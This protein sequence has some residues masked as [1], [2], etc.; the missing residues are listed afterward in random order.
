MSRKYTFETS[1]GFPGEGSKKEKKVEEKKK[2]CRKEKK[3]ACARRLVEIEDYPDHGAVVL[4]RAF[5]KRAGAV[6]KRK[7]K[8]KEL[9]PQDA[10]LLIQMTFRTYL[11]RRSQA[12]RA[13]RELA[14]SKAK[15]KEL[16][17]LFNNFSYRRHLARDAEE[18]QKFSEKIIVLLLTVDAIE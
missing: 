18:R 8:R 11:I 5:A 4:Q 6:E 10:A 2:E 17:A 1:S 13:L 3:G 7:G 14:I 9:S 15:L 16:R 12:L